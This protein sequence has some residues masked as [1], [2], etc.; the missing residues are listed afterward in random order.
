MVVG[1]IAL[2]NVAVTTAVLGQ[3]R[4]EPLGGVTETTVGGLKGEVAPGVP[5]SASLHPAATAAN[6]NAGIQSFLKFDTLRISFSSIQ[7]CKAIH[8][9]PRYQV[10]DLRIQLSVQD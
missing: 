8:A 2:L 3:T 6:R 10:R 5:L 1:F 4:V 9:E 7:P